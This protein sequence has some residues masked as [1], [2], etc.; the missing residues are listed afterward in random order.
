MQDQ[1][2]IESKKNR[3]VSVDTTPLLLTVEQHPEV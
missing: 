2:E 1:D 3:M